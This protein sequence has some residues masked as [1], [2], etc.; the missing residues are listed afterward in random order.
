MGFAAL[1]PSY[2]ISPIRRQEC[3]LMKLRLLGDMPILGTD[4]A[5]AS[6]EAAGTHAF[7]ARRRRD[8]GDAGGHVIAGG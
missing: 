4:R 1:Y 7:G 3:P 2:E 5:G 8:M 6:G